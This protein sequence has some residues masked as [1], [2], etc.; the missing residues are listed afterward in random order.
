MI[1]S[2][3]R[4]RV[5]CV[6]PATWALAN[7]YPVAVRRAA[8]ALLS[9]PGPRADSADPLDGV[10]HDVAGSSRCGVLHVRGHVG[11]GEPVEEVPRIVA[12]LDSRACVEHP[13]GIEEDAGL[14]WRGEG[15]HD[16]GVAFD[17]AQLQVVAHVRADWLV[18]V[19]ADPDDADLG[20]PSVLMVVTWASGAESIS[21]LSW[22][23]RRIT[24]SYLEARAVQRCGPRCAGSRANPGSLERL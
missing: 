19:Q 1:S 5:R 4:R 18:P 9:R 7:K 11:L 16:A 2:R 10:P 8:P 22:S 24:G 3:R 23:G 20:L 12:G 15:Q 6:E 13:V 17:V 21:S 14:A